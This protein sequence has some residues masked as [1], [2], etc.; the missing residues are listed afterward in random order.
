MQEMFT[1]EC[2]CAPALLKDI[3]DDLQDTYKK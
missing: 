1:R 2:T 3:F